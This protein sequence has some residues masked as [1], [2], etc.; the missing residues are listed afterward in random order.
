MDDVLIALLDTNGVIQ[1]WNKGGETITG[2]TAKYITGWNYSILHTHQNREALLH[3]NLLTQARQLGKSVYEGW[4]I[5]KNG[6]TLWGQLQL[7]PV[8]QQNQ[9]TGF[10]LIGR[11]LQEKKEALERIRRAEDLQYSLIAEVEDYAI[12][13]LDPKGFIANWNAGAERIKGYTAREIVGRHFSNFYTPEEQYV[14]KPDELLRV[15]RENGKAQAEGWRVRKDGTHFWASITITA[16]HGEN[17]EVLGFTKVTRDLT[18]K[19]KG[20]DALKSYNEMLRSKNRELEEL[21][22]ITSHDLQEPLRTITSLIEL[23][24]DSYLK[25]PDEQV[26]SSFKFIYDAASRMRQ[27]IKDIL[28]YSRLGR[29]AAMK[30]VDI[31]NILKLICDDLD[32]VIQESGAQIYFEMMPNIT[33]FESELKLLFQNLILNAIKFAKKD[34]PPEVYIS[35]EKI[36]GGWKFSV[37]DNGIGI[38][39]MHQQKVFVIFQ[40]LH[41]RSQYEGTGIGLAHCKKIVELHKGVIGVYSQPGQG[42]TFHFTIMD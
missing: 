42:S 29:N 19:K 6:V 10:V 9:L 39:P 20:E 38:E 33:A 14:N 25:H 11:N 22:Y 28:D 17:G 27:L 32:L 3:D 34:T 30:T 37:R 15:A 23:L 35:A 8:Y 40:R 2:Y 13:R 18:D 21:T 26:A 16:I 1:S 12:L 4:V 5:I 24:S 31:G 36:E 41:N 7:T